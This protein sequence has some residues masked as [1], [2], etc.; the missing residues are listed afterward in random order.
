M[1]HTN[2]TVVY[3]KNILTL[4]LCDNELFGYII[5]V[6]PNKPLDFANEVNKKVKQLVDK[7]TE[8]SKEL[9]FDV[10]AMN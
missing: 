1:L 3:V 2:S 4:L 8:M 6:N 5:K 10:L 7:F 9:I